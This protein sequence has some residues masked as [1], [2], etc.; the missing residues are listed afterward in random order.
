MGRENKQEEE[1]REV[2]SKERRRG[3]L[4]GKLPSQPQS[5]ERKI[6]RIKERK[7]PE[8]KR[9]EREIG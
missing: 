7:S 5:K 1:S 9:R 4:H 3:G 8:A 6:Y 2:R